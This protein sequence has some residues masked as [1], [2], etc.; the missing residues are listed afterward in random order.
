MTNGRPRMSL[1]FNISFRTLGVGEGETMSGFAV[2]VRAT[3]LEPVMCGVGSERRRE[4]EV[5]WR[6]D[7][8]FDGDAD[9]EWLL[10]LSI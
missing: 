8:G 1:R 4:R 3:A 5:L 2:F 7:C 9:V 10:A 6:D